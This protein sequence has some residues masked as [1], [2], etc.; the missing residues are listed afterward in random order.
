MRLT[1]R[2]QKCRLA[3]RKLV[4]FFL[5]LLIANLA[6]LRTC[7]KWAPSVVYALAI[8][9]LEQSNASASEPSIATKSLKTLGLIVSTLPAFVI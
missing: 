9:H 2:A 8:T 1:I 4:V 7:S 3:L 6:G 5:V